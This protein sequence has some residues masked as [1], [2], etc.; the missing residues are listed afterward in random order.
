MLENLDWNRNLDSCV[1]STTSGAKLK[2][3]R[4]FTLA[5]F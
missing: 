5:Y 1:K 3:S 2:W 4:I